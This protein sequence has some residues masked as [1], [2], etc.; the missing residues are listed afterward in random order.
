M[1]EQAEPCAADEG[2]FLSHAELLEW[3]QS[4]Q[5]KHPQIFTADDKLFGTKQNKQHPMD[6][7][8]MT[9]F[10]DDA[11]KPMRLQVRGS[12]WQIECGDKSPVYIV[13]FQNSNEL[14]QVEVTSAHEE[15]G[16]QVGWD[17]P[18]PTA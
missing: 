10:D 15:G 8:L 14:S 11:S 17:V 9:Y 12:R 16:W 4:M 2:K 1:E 13:K 6:T 5:R 18:P 3:H 7:K